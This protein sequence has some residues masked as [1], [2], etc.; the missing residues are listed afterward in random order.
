MDAVRFNVGDRVKVKSLEW[1]RSNVESIGEEFGCGTSGCCF[2]S[3]MS[4]LC[5]QFFT[6]DRKSGDRYKFEGDPRDWSFID[7]ML[8]SYPYYNNGDKLLLMGE[9]FKVDTGSDKVWIYNGKYNA[10]KLYNRLG[11]DG[12]EF[13]MKVLG[14]SMME[15]TYVTARSLND[16]SLLVHELRN[17]EESLDCSH[18]LEEGCTL[19]SEDT[20]TLL[21][22]N[23]RVSQLNNDE[24]YLDNPMGNNDEI[25]HCLRLDK[26]EFSN[27]V[28]GYYKDGDFPECSSLKDLER[29]VTALKGLCGSGA[30][31]KP[32]MD[33]LS[34]GDKVEFGETTGKVTR[35]TGGFYLEF[36]GRSNS[37]IYND[38]DLDKEKYSNE[39]LGYYIGGVSPYCK[40]LEDLT[41]LT[42]SL[43]GLYDLKTSKPPK[44]STADR[45]DSIRKRGQDSHDDLIIASMSACQMISDKDGIL[46]TQDMSDYDIKIGELRVLTNSFPDPNKIKFGVMKSG[47]EP[48]TVIPFKGRSVRILKE[49][50]SHSV[51]TIVKRKRI[52]F[53]F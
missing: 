37:W 38:L 49:E 36:G 42:K 2:V 5:G 23:Y 32:S 45:I 27:M 46:S 30:V 47:E 20:V 29:M 34:I 50:D 43:K 7:E 17:L 51:T 8:E 48:S 41:K 33:I 44:R 26:V 24:W 40:S 6:I 11:V 14:Y 12:G 31:H 15:W 10:E 53:G 52:Q 22:I 3:E 16:L 1:Y 4:E 28:L 39:V 19:K 25:F 35:G 18:S 21:H 13:S 9:T